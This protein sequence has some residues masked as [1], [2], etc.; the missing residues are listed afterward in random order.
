MKNNVSICLELI[1][2]CCKGKGIEDILVVGCGD[3]KEALG[4]KNLTG[5]KVIGVDIN[6]NF[7]EEVKKEV[8]LIEGNATALEFRDESFGLIYSYH[9][10]EHIQEYEKALLEIKR[11]LKRNGCF[12]V[13]VPNKNRVFGYISSPISF[14]KKLLWNFNDWKAR[15][16]GNFSNQ[17]GAHAGF[18]EGELFLNLSQLFSVVFPMRDEYYFEKYANKRSFIKFIKCL[19]L[20]DFFFP[21]N[22]FLCIKK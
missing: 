12:F 5:A 19:L 16:Y 7:N 6:H 20:E 11:V 10:L 4:I 17:K 8:K 14:N 1:K 18:Y 15:L 3:G 13:G 9:V 22:Y 2:K 21:S